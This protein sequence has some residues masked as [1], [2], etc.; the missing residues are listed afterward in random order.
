MKQKI[1]LLPGYSVNE[2]GDIFSDKTGKKVLVKKGTARLTVDRIRKT[3]K[4]KDFIF[5]N[6]KKLPLNKI[7]ELLKKDQ[8]IKFIDYK[9]KKIKKAIFLDHATFS[10]NAPAAQIKQGKVTKIISYWNI[11]KTCLS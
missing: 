11:Y 6:A 8:S 2:D 9:T 1:I 5:Y 10:D 7:K 3:Y 4:V